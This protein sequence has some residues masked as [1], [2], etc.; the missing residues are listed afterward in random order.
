MRARAATVLIQIGDPRARD[1]LVVL[2]DD[3]DP[4]VQALAVH[5]TGALRSETA[6]SKLLKKRK[7]GTIGLVVAEPLATL[8][9]GYLCRT[10][11][12]NVFKAAG[13]CATWELIDIEPRSLVSSK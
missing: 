9:R 3:P 4:D 7:N 1:A 13:K 2:L 6:V 12:E 5:A 11:P 10:G 8:V